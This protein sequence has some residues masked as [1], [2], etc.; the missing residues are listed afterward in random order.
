M[1]FFSQAIALPSLEQMRAIMSSSQF[2][3][4]G[5]YRH[6][7]LKALWPQY[8]DAYFRKLPQTNVPILILQGDLD[9]I[10]PLA[11]LSSL[12]SHYS[13]ANQHFVV[14]PGGTHAMA[15]TNTSSGCAPSL[16]LLLAF[17]ED[18][19]AALPTACLQSIVP[20]PFEDSALAREAFGTQSLWN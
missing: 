14:I 11:A 4:G 15:D 9:P 10:T 2:Y 17:V 7:K 12:R 5:G 3:L 8:E 1:C 6:R 16:E 20:P 18:P 13:K 19:R